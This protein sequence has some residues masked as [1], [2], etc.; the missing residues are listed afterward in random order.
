MTTIGVSGWMFLL[1]PAHSGCPGWAG[2]RRNIHLL[3]LIVVISRPYLHSPSTTIHGILLVQSMCSTVFFHNL[4]H[5]LHH[6][7]IMCTLLQKDTMPAP[8]HSVFTGRMAFL[9]PNQPH[10]NSEG[11]YYYWCNSTIVVW[12]IDHSG[13]LWPDGRMTCWWPNLSCFYMNSVL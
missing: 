8:H 5:Q 6:M 3:T 1:V 10:Q 13:G 7:Q 11:Q 2:T 9:L 12:F 4:S